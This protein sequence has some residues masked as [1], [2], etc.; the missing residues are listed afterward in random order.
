MSVA[1]GRVIG[2]RESS[3]DVTTF[4]Y[5]NADRLISE[6]RTGTRPY[7]GTYAYDNIGLRTSAVIVTNG[8]V[9]ERRRGTSGESARTLGNPLAL[10]FDL[11]KI[12][13]RWRAAGTFS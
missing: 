9:C 10:A 8:G 12:G 11:H 2:Q 5:D 3:G 1:G 4:S 13:Y 7:S 6:Q